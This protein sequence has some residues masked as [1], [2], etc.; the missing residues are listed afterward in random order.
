MEYNMK[1]VTIGYIEWR[2]GQDILVDAI[3]GLPE[4]FV[5]G[6]KFTMI[7]QDSS[8]M[9][10][11]LREK[12]LYKPWIEM[13]GTVKREKIHEILA[14][15]DVMI[16]PSREDPMPTVCAEAMM[17]NVPCLVSDSIG[18]ASYIKDGYDGLI[19][20]NEDVNNLQ[21]KIIWCIEHKEE[22]RKMGA[23]AYTIYDKVF[24]VKAFENSLL[25]H[26]SEMLEGADR[27]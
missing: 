3:C 21:K 17:H 6:C 20:N 24:S 7:G 2:K 26:V 14:Q 16:C 12:I 25:K 22:I 1:F 8:L 11:K 27:Q 4:N 18:T 19:F 9:A 13:I 5:S 15:T 10:Q 23:R